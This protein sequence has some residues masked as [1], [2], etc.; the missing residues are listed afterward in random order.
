MP[1]GCGA[2][3]GASLTVHLFTHGSVNVNVREDS[4]PNTIDIHQTF[5]VF[6]VCTTFHSPQ[7]ISASSCKNH[8]ASL[9]PMVDPLSEC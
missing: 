8:E 9:I 5:K 6:Y 7:N 3:V 2:P 1:S 4:F